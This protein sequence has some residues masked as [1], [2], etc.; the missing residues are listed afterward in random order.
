MLA[1][2]VH[3]PHVAYRELIFPQCDK[4][5]PSC[6]Q[7][8]RLRRRCPGYRDLNDLLFRNENEKVA[9][10]VHSRSK[11][12]KQGDG[13]GILSDRSTPEATLILPETSKLL[14]NITPNLNDQALGVFF[15]QYCSN[16][17]GCLDYLY[18]LFERNFL[19]DDILTETA[20]CL[21]VAYLSSSHA[22]AR[23]MF[24]A[25]RRYT[26]ILGTLNS[27]LSELSTARKDEM[28]VTV[29]LLSLFEVS[30]FNFK[31]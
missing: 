12:G 2:F 14:I 9:H 13:H 26:S 20:Q 21:G 31:S 10:K 5:K 16:F 23:L 3:T 6:G 28:I 29:I 4:A 15:Q 22:D 30:T 27:E 11:S 1:Y 7:C 8:V 17:A 19:R 25:S 18:P 24:E